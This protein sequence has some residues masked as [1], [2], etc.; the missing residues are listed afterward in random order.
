[1]YIRRAV[2]TAALVAAPLAFA[3]PAMA[4]PGMNFGCAPCVDTPQ[5][6]EDGNPI[7]VEV[8]IWNA[9]FDGT[10]GV[11]G[12]GKGAWEQATSGNGWESGVASLNGGAWEKAFPAE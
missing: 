12:D 7:T 8:P 11:F 5:T 4:A 2:I 3:A 10:N 6:D 1:M 9:F